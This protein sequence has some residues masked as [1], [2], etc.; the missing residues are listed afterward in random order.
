MPKNIFEQ[1]ELNNIDAYHSQF[2]SSMLPSIK[3]LADLQKAIDEVMHG[4]NPDFLNIASIL[5][6][7][8]KEDIVEILNDILEKREITSNYEGVSEDHIYLHRQ[9]NFNLLIRLI[10]DGEQNT[11]Y[12]NE[13][14]IFVI[15]PTN[16][17]IVVPCYE[18]CS[19]QNIFQ[20]P[21]PIKR[22][23]DC[24]FKPNKVYYF[25]AY[26]YILDFDFESS[27][28]NFVLIIHSDPKG[29]I[30]WIY[31]RETL[32]PIQSICTNLQASRILL[33]VR[34]LGE[35]K[36]S[37]AIQCIENLTTSNYA[38][39]VRWE[40]VQSLSKIAPSNCLEILK[41][42]AENDQDPILKQAAIHSLEMTMAKNC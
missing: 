3:T 21:K 14:D 31:N 16:T 28:N 9:N 42:L 36:A 26:K 32:E 7:L 17:E 37:Q 29:W 8:K 15:N 1:D 2:T 40:A 38:N 10:G 34:L 41:I 35:M 19:E 39:F 20:K 23:N 4:D 22:V 33:Y 11:L 24:H 13:F 6:S 27:P 25:E 30:T 5:S 18:F 12:T